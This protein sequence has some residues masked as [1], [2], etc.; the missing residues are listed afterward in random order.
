MNLL[1]PKSDVSFKRIFGEH[2]KYLIAFL[3]SILKHPIPISNANYLPNELNPTIDNGKT[4]IVDVHC[5]DQLGR[6]FIVE[7]QLIYFPSFLQRAHFNLSKLCVQQLKSG[8]D[9]TELKPIYS[10]NILFKDAFPETNEYINNF[11]FLNTKNLKHQFVEAEIIFI[12]LSKWEKLVKFDE[13]NELHHWLKFLMD[14]NFYKNLSK[15]DIEKYGFV[16]DA[17]GLLEQN[18]YTIEEIRAHDRYMDNIRTHNSIMRGAI[19]TGMAEGIEKGMAEGLEKGIAEGIEKGI[20]EGI[21][22]G[23]EKGME[24]GKQLAFNQMLLLVQ[25][26]KSRNFSNEELSNKYNIPEDYILQLISSTN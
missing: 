15:E 5:I 13:E 8:E 1:D 9:Y 17:V 16:L 22:E 3:N 6:Q 14:P 19:E 4:T 2:Q 12:E 23:I 21:A 20:A 10:V 24:K 7:M 26:I 25:D 18:S 11:K